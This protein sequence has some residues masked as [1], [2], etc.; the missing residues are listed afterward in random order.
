M[1]MMNSYHYYYYYCYDYDDYPSC[2]CCSVLL[3]DFLSL[4]E[5]DLLHLETSLII[6]VPRMTIQTEKKPLTVCY[7]HPV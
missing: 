7:S 6:N 4:N 5:H 1:T 3:N 2:C